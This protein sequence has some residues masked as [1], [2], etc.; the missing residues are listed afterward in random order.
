MLDDMKTVFNDVK[1]LSQLLSDN[2]YKPITF[3]F[4]KMEDLGMEDSL[5]IKLNARGKPLTALENFKARLTGRLKKLNLNF[6]DE[7]ENNLDVKWTDLFWSHCKESFDLS[8]L[9][10]FG[11]LLMNKGIC[12]EDNNWSDSLEWSNSLDYEKIDAEIFN[13]IFLT[14]NFLSDNSERIEE[15]C[16]LIFN[17]V[18]E[19]RTF[20]DRVLFHA[21]TTFIC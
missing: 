3:K 5:Y 7:L 18:K 12:S 13:T 1:N 14:L 19:K 15:T 16:Q 6:A 21:V 20:K 9:T 2:E 11:V 4:L 8:Y 10:F 17:A